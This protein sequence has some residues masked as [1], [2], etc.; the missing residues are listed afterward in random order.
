[1]NYLIDEANYIGKGANS[2]IN[3]LHDFLDCLVGNEEEL[4]LQD[5]NCVGQNKNNAA[6]Q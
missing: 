3:L 6:I 1:M 5:N 2:T 4:P